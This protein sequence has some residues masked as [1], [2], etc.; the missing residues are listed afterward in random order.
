[1]EGKKGERRRNI[2][3]KNRPLAQGEKNGNL[4]P[5]TKDVSAASPVKREAPSPENS[6]RNT[7]AE[8]TSFRRKGKDLPSL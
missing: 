4:D 8:N 7:A 6:Q 2:P 3:K 5:G 1:M